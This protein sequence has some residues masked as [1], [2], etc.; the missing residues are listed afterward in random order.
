[1]ATTENGPRKKIQPGKL[2]Q[3]ILPR[4]EDQYRGLKN[5]YVVDPTDIKVHLNE[6]KK[7]YIRISKNTT[8]NHNEKNPSQ[9]TNTIKSSQQ[10]KFESAEKI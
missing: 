8:N 5:F 10:N 6:L 4:Q 7:I 1:L 9:V 2:Q 3:N